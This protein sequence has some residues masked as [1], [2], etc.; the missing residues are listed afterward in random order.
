MKFKDVA[1]HYVGCYLNKAETEALDYRRLIA[2]SETG[3][4]VSSYR[5]T[6]QIHSGDK[7]F[8]RP[9]LTHT[10]DYAFVSDKPLLYPLSAMTEE[11]AKELV[12]IA[13]ERKLKVFGLTV[14]WARVEFSGGKYGTWQIRW[15]Q[16][17]FLGTDETS[18]IFFNALSPAQFKYL[19]DNYF[20]LWD[21]IS[22]NEAI[23]V[24]T[25]TNNPYK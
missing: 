5:Y 22:N 8:T 20:D 19:I 11:Q 15:Q 1:K 7:E 16:S 6:T 3:F 17:D 12:N 24:T 10:F 2:V 23:D 9:E 4:T 25:L 14:G 21:L 13:M 18:C